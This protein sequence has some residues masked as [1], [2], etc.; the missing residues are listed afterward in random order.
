MDVN[1]YDRKSSFM[2]R[3]S[4]IKEVFVFRSSSHNVLGLGLLSYIKATR[5]IAREKSEQI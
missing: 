3:K 4:K 1:E 5:I 2:T